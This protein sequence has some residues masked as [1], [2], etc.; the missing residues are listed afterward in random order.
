MPRDDASCIVLRIS[1]SHAP[2]ASRRLSYAE[3]REAN[4]IM[5]D[6]S[7]TRERSNSREGGSSGSSGDEGHSSRQD[8]PRGAPSM[9]RQ[10]SDG[11]QGLAPM[12]VAPSVFARDS[13][14]AGE[15]ITPGTPPE[16][17]HRLLTCFFPKSPIKT[18]NTAVPYYLSDAG[19]PSVSPGALSGFG[20]FR[21]RF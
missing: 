2:T 9:S 20:S 17:T 19:E 12:R 11:S 15:E 3:A 6:G 18:R 5:R 10:G 4:R 8:L 14:E 1:A 21:T 7:S 16:D 13:W